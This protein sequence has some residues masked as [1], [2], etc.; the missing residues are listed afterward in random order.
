[1]TPV[2]FAA[3]TLV[4]PSPGAG[5]GE[6]VV[7]L[8]VEAMPEPEPALKYQLLP[9]VRE[10]TPG[11]AAQDYLKCFMEQ[12]PLFFSKRGID[13]RTRYLKMPLAELAAAKLRGYG[14]SALR[15]ADRAARMV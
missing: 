10:L 2:L 7:R 4:A 8:H 5:A 3:L 14:G 9:E 12:R 1:M 6:T 11:N 13:E 15:E